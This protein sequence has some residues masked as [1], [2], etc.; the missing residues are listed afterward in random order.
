MQHSLPN[1]QSQQCKQTSVMPI[2]Y[3][4]LQGTTTGRLLSYNPKSKKTRVLADGFF[5]ANGVA[6]SPDDSFVLVVE[7]LSVT[8]HKYWLK[9][10]K[11]CSYSVPTVTPKLSKSCS[12]LHG[13]WVLQL[14]CVC[15][16]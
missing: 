6:L 3:A 4:S 11:V 8:V 14:E 13:L 5:Y 16:I 12:C 9:G 15:C 1:N 7:T 10:P 2:V